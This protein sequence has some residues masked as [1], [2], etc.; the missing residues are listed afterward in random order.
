MTRSV[1][2]TSDRSGLYVQ[3]QEDDARL[4][5]RL[6]A[7]LKDTILPSHG[8]LGYDPSAKAW[9]VARLGH[10]RLWGWCLANFPHAM[11]WEARDTPEYESEAERRRREESQ[12]KQKAWEE[13]QKTRTP[14]PPASAPLEAAY[15]LFHLKPSAP[16]WVAE[17]V[18]RAS[19]ARYHPDAGGNDAAMTAINRAIETIRTQRKGETNGT[20]TG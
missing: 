17:A 6:I 12:A 9:I 3:I 15:A 2:V 1:R 10:A 16:L 8:F 18:Y 11:A 4:R 5:R 13:Q 7:S 19:A 14:A 20:S